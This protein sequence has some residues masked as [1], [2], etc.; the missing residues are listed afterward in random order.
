MILKNRII[1]P[2]ITKIRLLKLSAILVTTFLLLNCTNEKHPIPKPKSAKGTPTEVITEWQNQKFSMFIHFGLYSVPGGIWNGQQITKGYSEQI[3]AHANISKADYRQLAKIFNPVKWNSDSIV[4]LA[5]SA[6]MKSV[7]ITAKHHDGFALFKTN[8]SKFNITDATPY[9]R[10]LLLEL[11]K[12]CQKYGLKFGV[13]FSLIDWDFEGALPPSS[14]NSDSIPPLHHQL[15]LDQVKELMSNYGPVSEIWFDM[16]KPTII[17][18]R[19]IANLV[20]ELQPNCLI[21]GRLWNDQGDF[22]VMGDNASPDFRMGQP[23][24]TPAS[25]FDETWGYRSWQVRKDPEG[26]ANE[27]IKSLIR[28]VTNGGNYLLNIGPAGDGSVVPFEKEVLLKMG[29]W[30]NDHQASFINSK[31]ETSQ[32]QSWG[33]MASSGNK[34]FLF[35]LNKPTGQTI[36]VNGLYS[37]IESISIEEKLDSLVKYKIVPSGTAITFQKN[38]FQ[39]IPIPVITIQLKE[40]VNIEPEGLLNLKSGNPITLDEKN[41]IPYHSYSGKDYYSTK[42]TTIKLEW[43]IRTDSIRDVKIQFNHAGN[44]N[45][46]QYV[47]TLNKS[48]LI[49]ESADAQD[50]NKLNTQRF[51]GIQLQKGLNNITICLRDRSNPHQDIV[52][53]NFTITID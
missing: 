45:L 34:L 5:K 41:A 11:S 38:A 36:T 18:S 49:P 50:G 42:P 29:K 4:Q 32:S 35:I 43:N 53:K 33:T 22:A 17:Q 6:G 7:I 24:Q 23:W 39:K 19:E 25:M 26:K 13:Y 30:I 21:S 51:S 12:A 31:P 16:G 3:R 1:K 8:F 52:L 20:K 48:N 9:G 47:I 37:K 14:H 2:F 15:N 40:N 44:D 27:K 10:D 46:N 28:T